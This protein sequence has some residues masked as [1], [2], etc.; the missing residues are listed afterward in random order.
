MVEFQGH[1]YKVEKSKKS[2]KQGQFYTAISQ[3]LR[4]IEVIDVSSFN[5]PEFIRIII[6]LMIITYYKK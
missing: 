2:R 5:F 4:P 6:L 1:I 3:D